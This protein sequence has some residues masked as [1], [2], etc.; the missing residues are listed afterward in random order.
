MTKQTTVVLPGSGATPVEISPS[1]LAEINTPTISGDQ[2]PFTFESID[3][4][5][6]KFLKETGINFRLEEMHASNLATTVSGVD[7]SEYPSVEAVPDEY[8]SYTLQRVAAKFVSDQK[9]I[10]DGTR[11]NTNLQFLYTVDFNKSGQSSYIPHVSVAFGANVLV[12]SN[13]L[14]AFDYVGNKSHS[15]YST[16]QFNPDDDLDVF[17]TVFT[18]R[19]K[20]IIGKYQ[21]FIGGLVEKDMTIDKY[22]EIMGRI[23]ANAINFPKESI[24]VRTVNAVAK[25]KHQ[26]DA[27]NPWKIDLEGDKVNYWTLYNNFTDAVKAS[28]IST[29]I[30]QMNHLSNFFLNN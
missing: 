25:Q 8:K 16:R 22:Y 30:T 11:N 28:N 13:G 21:D 1:F 19:N 3:S 15:K 23:H 18:K 2:K 12:C 29:R 17:F 7:V 9:I 10:D 24:D 4:N 6:R 14:I 26:K 5:I 27:A 20:D